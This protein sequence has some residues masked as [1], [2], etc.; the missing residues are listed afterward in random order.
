M[1]LKENKFRPWIISFLPAAVITLLTTYVIPSFIDLG[2]GGNSYRYGF[3]SPAR[4]VSSTDTSFETL[5]SVDPVNMLIN[6]AFI[7]V[8]L[9]AINHIVRTIKMKKKKKTV[10]FVL[11][12]L[13]TIVLGALFTFLLVVMILIN[14]ANL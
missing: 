9:A 7:L 10:S 13:T 8:F 6:F 11:A 3:P 4:N 1:F 5:V 2:I 14:A 12:T